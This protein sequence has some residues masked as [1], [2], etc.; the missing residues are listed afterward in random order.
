[1]FDLECI[2]PIFDLKY[3]VQCLLELKYILLMFKVKYIAPFFD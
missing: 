1:M 3:I 2:V